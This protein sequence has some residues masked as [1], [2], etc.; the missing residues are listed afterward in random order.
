MLD[1][2]KQWREERILRRAERQDAID[3]TLEECIQG[4]L[5]IGHLRQDE[6][7]SILQMDIM[8]SSSRDAT[9]IMGF[10]SSGNVIINSDKIRP[11]T[12]NLFRENEAY[13]AR[14]REYFRE[15]YGLERANIAMDAAMAVPQQKRWVDRINESRSAERDNSPSR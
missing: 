10:D 1:F 8:G 11:G 14:V 12:Q 6:G 15:T 5:E 2:L 7:L 3:R 13:Q 4:I 9:G